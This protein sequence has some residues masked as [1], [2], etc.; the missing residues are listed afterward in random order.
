MQKVFGPPGFLRARR[1]QILR[2]VEQRRPRLRGGGVLLFPGSL[3]A[4]L[5]PT[6]GSDGARRAPLASSRQEVRI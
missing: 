1:M 4:F 5:R 2:R 3:G 6:P